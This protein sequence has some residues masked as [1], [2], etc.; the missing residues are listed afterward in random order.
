[1]NYIEDVEKGIEFCQQ[2]ND[3]IDEVEN[4]VTNKD[5]WEKLKQAMD[6]MNE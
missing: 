3:M 6:N 5:A 2:L 4:K 1:M